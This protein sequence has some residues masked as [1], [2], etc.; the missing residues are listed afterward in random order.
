MQIASRV[1]IYV[2]IHVYVCIIDGGSRHIAESVVEI[3]SYL[4]SS[5]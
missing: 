2:R 3:N 1:D 4:S 5:Q